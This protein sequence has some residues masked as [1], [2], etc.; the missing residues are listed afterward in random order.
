MAATK[1]AGNSTVVY[2]AVPLTPYV[3]E[4]DVHQCDCRD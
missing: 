4:S 3:T 1:G 2:N